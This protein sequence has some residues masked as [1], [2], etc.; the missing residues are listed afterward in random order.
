LGD[1]SVGHKQTGKTLDFHCFRDGK[2]CELVEFYDTAPAISCATS[3]PSDIFIDAGGGPHFKEK[4]KRSWRFSRAEKQPAK[5]H[6]GFQRPTL[7]TLTGA[8]PSH[9]IH[10]P[11][12][13]FDICNDHK[14]MF[15]AAE[16]VATFRLNVDSIDSSSQTR[17]R[18]RADRVSSQ[19]LADLHP[20]FAVGWTVGA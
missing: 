19:G 11:P 7:T 8:K 5:R 18:V 2:I 16:L 12:V 10:W 1:C 9:R 4:L 6:S 14:A 17:L 3:G 13:T 20:G 15:L